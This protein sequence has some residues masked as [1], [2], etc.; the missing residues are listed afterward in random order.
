MQRPRHAGG[1]LAS[2]Q[3][4]SYDDICLDTLDAEITA[5]QHHRNRAADYP[6]LA[7]ERRA[8]K[9]GH[10]LVGKHGIEALRL[11]PERRRT[12]GVSLGPT[13]A[14][15]GNASSSDVSAKRAVP[16]VYGDLI[17]HLL[18]PE[19]AISIQNLRGPLPDPR[20]SFCPRAYGYLLTCAEVAASSMSLAVSFGYDT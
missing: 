18:S 16:S 14:G 7:D 5:H 1:E 12:A 10:A 11:C 17:F 2:G 3:G 8:R 6:H 19:V 15:A 4:L 13:T 9:T 20:R